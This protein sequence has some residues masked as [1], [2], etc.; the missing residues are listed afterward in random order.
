[1]QNI[2]YLSWNNWYLKHLKQSRFNIAILQA[3]LASWALEEI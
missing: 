2:L 1:M 3:Q